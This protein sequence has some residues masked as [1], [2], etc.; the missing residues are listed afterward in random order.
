MAATVSVMVNSTVPFWCAVATREP[1]RG[2]RSPRVRPDHIGDD[3]DGLGGVQ[4]QLRQRL[5]R[6]G[7][8]G[9]GDLFERFQRAMDE[10]VEIG[11]LRVQLE[12]FAEQ[13]ELGDL[14]IDPTDTVSERAQRVVAERR[15]IE[16]PG[17]FWSIRE[18]VEAVFLRSCTKKADIGLG[19]P[20]VTRP[21]QALGQAEGQ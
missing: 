17:R 2:R 8:P 18:S 21:Q 14:V 7:D 20:R 6:P 19:K 10:G 12:P 4:V 13:A 9:A 16:V 3:L 11:G 5:K 1:G 15:I